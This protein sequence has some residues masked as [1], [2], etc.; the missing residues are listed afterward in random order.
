MNVELI[1]MSEAEAK[2]KLQAYKKKLASMKQ[3]E[4]NK[5]VA[6][7]YEM[8]IAGYRALAKGTPLLDLEEVFRKCPIDQKLRPRL[9]VAR[10]D[11]KEVHVRVDGQRYIFATGDLGTWNVPTGFKP[12]Q[13]ALNHENPPGEGWI[14]GYARVPMVPADKRPDKGYPSDWQILWEVE[15]WADRSSLAKP[16]RDPYL[17]K[18]IGGMLFAVIAEWDLTE[19]ERSIMKTRI[20]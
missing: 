8:A 4:A 7:Q 17:L 5:E 20:D 3:S 14:D 12:S 1:Q 9:A 13:I 19:L 10:A 2:E 11:R 16:D 18:H 6:T 15:A